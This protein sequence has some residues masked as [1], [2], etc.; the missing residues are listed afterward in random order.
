MDK[1]DLRLSDF[2]A[3]IFDN[4]GVLVDSEAIHIE[5]ERALLAEIGLEYDHATYLSRF[6][7]LSNPDFYAE[8]TS[9]FESRIGGAFPESFADTL[10]DRIWPRIMAEL[11]PLSG[12]PALVEAF[13]GKTAVASSAP[14]ERLEKKLK[15]AGL[16]RLFDPHI[17]SAEMVQKGKPAPDIFLQAASQIC[18]EPK[19]CVVIEDS[20]NG[21]RAAVAAGMTA[22]GF[23]GGGHC[24][25]GLA[26]RLKANGATAIVSSHEM[27][28]TL[29]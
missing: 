3:I 12:V 7:G 8:L 9:D 13:D 21:V 4:D 11:L 26:R 28:R 15:I 5:V 22:I 25:A 17:Y 16:F 18:V 14:V 2:G 6:V 10:Q 1:T 20:V 23:T 19:R 29:I 27:L 24:D